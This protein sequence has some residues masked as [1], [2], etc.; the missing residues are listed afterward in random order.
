M[1]EFEQT[2]IPPLEYVVKN[3]QLPISCPTKDMHLQT[4]HPRVYLPLSRKEPQVICPYCDT[5]FTLKD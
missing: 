5:K 3:S 2:K 1:T 4:M